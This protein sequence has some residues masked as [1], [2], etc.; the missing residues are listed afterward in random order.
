M[1]ATSK[2]QRVAV[3]II[4]SQ[5]ILL[6]CRYK[7]GRTYYVIPGGDIEPDLLDK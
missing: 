5:R 4:R 1:E 2:Q 7:N 6:L 3:I